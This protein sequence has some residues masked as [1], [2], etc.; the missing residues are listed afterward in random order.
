MNHKP[1]T[2]L[3]NCPEYH[4]YFQ[5]YACTEKMMIESLY[6]NDIKLEKL[7]KI[8]NLIIYHNINKFFQTKLII[9]NVNTT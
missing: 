6:N 5:I 2:Q 4:P 1:Q 9:K 8:K 3:P 7:F